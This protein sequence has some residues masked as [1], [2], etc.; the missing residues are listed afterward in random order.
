VRYKS[1][2]LILNK[3]NPQKS[4]SPDS[5]MLSKLGLFMKHEE[6]PL[7]REVSLRSFLGLSGQED[8]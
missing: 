8:K 3:I 7:K 5:A 4:A 6:N 1:Y 2:A